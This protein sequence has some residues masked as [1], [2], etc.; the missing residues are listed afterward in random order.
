MRAIAPDRAFELAKITPNS[1][2]CEALSDKLP[3]GFALLKARFP[4][5]SEEEKQREREYLATLDDDEWP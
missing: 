2:V 3:G 4:N 5:W 1:E